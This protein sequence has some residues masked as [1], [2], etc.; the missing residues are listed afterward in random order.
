MVRS[1][2]NLSSE[3]ITSSID[4]ALGCLRANFRTPS[5]DSAG[6]Y[7]YLDDARP[8]VTASAVGLYCFGLAAVQFERTDE[9]LRHLISQQVTEPIDQTGGWAVRTTEGFP[10]V[11]ATAWVVRA[12]SSPGTRLV[13]TADSL[14]LGASWI[15]GNQNTDL[16]WGSYRG[17]PSRVF[18][19]ALAMLSLEECGAS[20]AVIA[21]AQKWL[22]DAQ[23]P[24]T[25]A[26]G[27]LP[28]A[29]PT[30]L[31]TSWVLLAL[32]NVRG[33]LTASGVRQSADWLLGRIEPGVH[34][35]KSTTVED[36]DVPFPR[37]KNLVEFQN[38]LP[39]FAGPMAITALIKAGVDP[40]QP[41]L[42]DAIQ[43]ILDSQL[44]N[45]NWELPRSPTRPSIWAVWPF[46]SALSVFRSAVFPTRDS[47]ASLLFPGCAIIQT[48][49]SSRQLTRRLLIRNALLDWLR[50]RRTAVT[51]WAVAIV[52]ALIPLALL[53]NGQ[54]SWA[55]FLIAL[56]VP[57]LLLVFQLVWERRRRPPT[58]GAD[59]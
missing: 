14:Q 23:S 12:M 37:N 42:F 2:A 38:S 8:G 30:I 53:V 26:W 49:G 16:G 18:T 47:G 41:L 22:I 51:L 55:E 6:W 15:E 33:A 20:E 4:R 13:R 19:T 32:L 28:A 35:E 21:D 48:A 40:L 44:T 58:T 59:G 45:G 52:A 24:G 43:G 50:R 9:V 3:A 56:I 57:A 17:Q 5:D 10:I 7:H 34:V 29:E 1:E 46:V 25:P 36:Y 39:H 27:P 54:L 31:H 11:E